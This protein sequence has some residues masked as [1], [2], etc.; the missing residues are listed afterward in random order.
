M[1]P[2]STTC[3]VLLN[4]TTRFPDNDKSLEHAYDVG[5]GC[6]LVLAGCAFHSVTGKNSRLWDGHELGLAREW[7]RGARSVPLACQGNDFRRVGDP[8]FLAVFERVGAG[9]ECRAAIRP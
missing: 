3:P 6:A 8:H 4:E 7:V 1:R 2:A 5:R 9:S